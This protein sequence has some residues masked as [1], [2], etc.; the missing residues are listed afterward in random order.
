LHHIKKS[1]PR[2]AAASSN[3]PFALSGAALARK[4]WMGMSICVSTWNLTAYRVTK[5]FTP[6]VQVKLNQESG[7]NV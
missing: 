5:I 2:P 7:D 4:E 1:M 6:A 3:G